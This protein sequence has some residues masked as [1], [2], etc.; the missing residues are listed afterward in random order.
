MRFGGVLTPRQTPGKR[1]PSPKRA[2]SRTWCSVSL[3]NPWKLLEHECYIFVR[4]ETLG[5][6]AP[7]GRDLGVTSHELLLIVVDV[8]RS[9]A[10]MEK[11][12]RR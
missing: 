12:F 10:H 11:P 9:D 1:R 4:H 5:L 6:S 8:A 2:P 3:S 7:C